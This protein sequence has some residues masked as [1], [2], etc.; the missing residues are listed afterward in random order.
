[1]NMTLFIEYN[2]QIFHLTNVILRI[3]V[4]PSANRIIAMLPI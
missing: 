4:L 2:D 3:I 1:M